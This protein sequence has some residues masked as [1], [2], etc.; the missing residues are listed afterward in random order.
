MYKRQLI[1]KLDKQTNYPQIKRELSLIEFDDILTI[2]KQNQLY[3]YNNS[4]NNL[5]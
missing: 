5:T 3:K 1:N 2:L 4:I